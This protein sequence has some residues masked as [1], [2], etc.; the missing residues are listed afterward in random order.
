MATEP[1][2]EKDAADLALKLADLSLK[3]IQFF[4]VISVAFGGYLLG[5]GGVLKADTL[6]ST[7]LVLAGIYGFSAGGMAYGVVMIQRKIGNALSV[8]REQ[9][10]EGSPQAAQRINLYSFSFDVAPVALIGTWVLVMYLILF[11]HA[12]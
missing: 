6:S 5:D 9:V 10:E 2:T 7:R 8:A 12:S 1:L 11:H 4:V 3:G